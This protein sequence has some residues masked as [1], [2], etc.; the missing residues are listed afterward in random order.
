MNKG[1]LYTRPLFPWVF[2]P[3]LDGFHRRHGVF[4]A[5]PS[6]QGRNRSD[7]FRE[8]VPSQVPIFFSCLSSSENQRDVTHLD[9]V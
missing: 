5:P 2:L 4:A 1:G 6:P 8:I 3:T 9:S 7:Y